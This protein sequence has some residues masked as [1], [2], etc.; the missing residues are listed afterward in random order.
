MKN[1]SIILFII[2]MTSCYSVV[3]EYEENEEILDYAYYINSGWNT[4]E[5]VNLTDTVSFSD[6][7]EILHLI[8]RIF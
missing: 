5:A 2:F 1:I 3:S 7:D 8:I 6:H 4:F